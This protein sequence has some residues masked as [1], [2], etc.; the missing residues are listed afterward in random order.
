MEHRVIHLIA[1]GVHGADD[2]S[3]RVAQVLSH[4]QQGGYA[5]A[6]DFQRPGKALGGADADAKAR[7]RPRALSHGNEAHSGSGEIGGAQHAVHQRH[8]GAA[9]GQ[10]GILIGAAQHGAVFHHGGGYTFRRGF[11]SQNLHALPPVMV[12]C[13][14]SLWS[15]WRSMVT[16][17]VSSGRASDTFSLHSTAHTPPRSR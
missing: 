8:Q 1:P 2:G 3:V 6:G 12:I 13:R 15:A 14:Q 17:T 5:A 11:K 4:C 10:A 7:K 16:K 9:V